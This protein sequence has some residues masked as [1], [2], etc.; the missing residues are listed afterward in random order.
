MTLRQERT[1]GREKVHTCITSEKTI[2]LMCL[3]ACKH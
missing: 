1:L 2:Q 3:Y